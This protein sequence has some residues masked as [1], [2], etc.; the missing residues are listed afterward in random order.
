MLFFGQL[1]NFI[2]ISEDHLSKISLP[3]PSKFV[4]FWLVCQKVSTKTS[5]WISM[6][7]RW[8]AGPDP[9]WTPL[10]FGAGPNKGIYPGILSHLL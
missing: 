10:T 6:K 7:L 3:P 8:R 5:E 2:H 4:G 9:E 1:S